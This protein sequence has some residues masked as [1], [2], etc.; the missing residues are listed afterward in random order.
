[1]AV[2]LESAVDF[3]E[4]GSLVGEVDF[5]E[6]REENL[7]GDVGR[8]DE[9]GTR[10]FGLVEVAFVPAGKNGGRDVDGALGLSGERGGWE[11][12]IWDFKCEL[13]STKN[14]FFVVVVEG[15]GAIRLGIMDILGTG[16]AD[17]CFAFFVGESSSIVSSPKLIVE[18]FRRSWEEAVGVRSSSSV[19]MLMSKRSVWVGQW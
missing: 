14:G 18:N 13:G 12:T 1:M 5:E 4:E 6:E 7:V 17:G 10:F 11:G 9:E 16:N 3:E 2:V 19:R 15:S 8:V